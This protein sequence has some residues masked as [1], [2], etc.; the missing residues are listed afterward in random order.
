MPPGNAKFLMDSVFGLAQRMNHFR[1]SDAEIGLFCAVVIITAD[2]PGLRNPELVHKM[3]TKLK[4]VFNNILLPQHPDQATIFSELMT[5]IHDLRTLNTLHM[6]KFLQQF[7]VNSDAS[8]DQSMRPTENEKR[9]GGNKI[10]QNP[11][12]PEQDSTGNE[13]P[14]S[15]S[16]S[17]DT[18]ERRSPIGSV[19]SSESAQNGGSGGGPEPRMMTGNDIRVSVPNSALISALTS[20]TAAA[21]APN[22]EGSSEQQ[23]QPGPSHRQQTA[24]ANGS[25]QYKN[26]SSSTNILRKLE[27]P[28]DSGID[29]PLRVQGSQSSSTSVCSSPRSTTAATCPDE[30]V[31]KE[32]VCP[33]QLQ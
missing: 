30:S 27:S 26:S 6:E 22:K 9:K 2:R 19:S 1:L 32:P 33:G 8:V 20:S 25:K 23:P 10:R 21:A 14:Q 4:Q 16:S 13:S 3:Q 5:M 29:S 17:E 12:N 18:R 7:K 24:A 28:S 31:K 15:Y 11:R